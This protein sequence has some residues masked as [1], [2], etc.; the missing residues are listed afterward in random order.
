[1]FIL[2]LNG[3]TYEKFSSV[4]ENINWGGY[5]FYPST[6]GKDLYRNI[7]R[8]EQ[9]KKLL[10]GIKGLQNDPRIKPFLAVD[11]E[12]GN[13]KIILRREAGF[14]FFAAPRTI[15][16]KKGLK[17]TSAWGNKIAGFLGKMGFNTNLAPV[18]DVDRPAGDN[19]RLFS[20]DPEVV[21]KNARIFIAENHKKGIICTL[22][23]FPGRSSGRKVDIEKNYSAARDQRPFQG[24]LANGFSDIVMVST[25]EFPKLDKARPAF[26]SKK[27]IDRLRYGLNFQGVIMTDD[28]SFIFTKPKQQ[29][30]ERT[31][32]EAINAGN[33]L[34]LF[35][36]NGR[37]DPQLANKLKK[38]LYSILRNEKISEGR[39]EESFVRILEL[40]KKYGIEPKDIY[41]N[42]KI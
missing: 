42:Y 9:L 17:Q 31:I 15:A 10:A 21:M 36:N 22:K 19:K 25:V 41:L 1:M 14:P 33:D 11:L 27:I 3:L 16:R 2:G 12:G 28:L 29:D 38:A 26:L 40:K 7:K 37:Y 5:I 4:S 32:I 35:A 8:P 34:L 20:S 39:I 6:K 18:V 24:L 13:I 30:L 23:H